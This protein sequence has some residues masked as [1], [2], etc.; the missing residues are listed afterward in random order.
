MALFKDIEDFCTVFPALESASWDQFKIFCELVEHKTFRNEIL[1]P[2]LYSALNTAY[3]ASI[4]TSP[5]PMTGA[6]AALL[7]EVRRAVAFHTVHEAARTLA[8]TIDSAGITNA[9][10]DRRKPATMWRTTMTLG[11]ILSQAHDFTDLCISHLLANDGALPQWADSPIRTALRESFIRDMRHVTPYI[12]I[13]GPWLLH[14]LRPAMRAVQV[15]PV[16]KIIGDT[17]YT[18]ILNKLNS[19][20]PLLATEAAILEEARPAILHLAIADQ[21]VPLSMQLDHQGAWTWEM[22]TSGSGISA[23]PKSASNDKLNAT[24][25]SHQTKGQLHLAQLDQFIN[26]HENSQFRSGASDGMYSLM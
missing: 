5:T 13:S 10:T 16:K 23:G 25:R 8:T 26:P 6:L 22:A 4:A 1:G 19:G 7:P 9:E 12:N 18:S 24:V 3:Q 11:S 17:H 2:T 20:A 15:G 21:I 14:K